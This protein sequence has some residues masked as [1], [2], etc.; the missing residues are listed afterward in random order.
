MNAHIPD[1]W[2][3]TQERAPSTVMPLVVKLATCALEFQ[4]RRKK[5][6]QKGGIHD[7]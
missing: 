6:L 7:R 5:I 2:R 4:I 1:K 3:S